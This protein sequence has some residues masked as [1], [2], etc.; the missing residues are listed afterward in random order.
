MIGVNSTLARRFRLTIP[1]IFL[2]YFQYYFVTI[3]IHCLLPEGFI[4]C[5]TR[6]T[7][8]FAKQRSNKNDE[9]SR[10]NSGPSS[11]HII[12]T[13]TSIPS[14][15]YDTA[16]VRTLICAIFCVCVCVCV[17][18]REAHL[19]VS[20][21]YMSQSETL[22]VKKDSMPQ[23][24]TLQ[25]KK[26]SCDEIRQRAT[27]DP[28][29]IFKQKHGFPVKH[30]FWSNRSVTCTHSLHSLTIINHSMRI[31]KRLG[32]YSNSDNRHVCGV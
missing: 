10:N 7:F 21:K 16:H 24:E 8:S 3:Q 5:L 32:C 26:D 19:P 18:V 17:C 31:S 22:Q 30:C 23:S 15:S 13:H 9:K 27:R 2:I 28:P 1:V 14:C 29:S 6:L 4:R 25:V 11:R 12:L 20:P